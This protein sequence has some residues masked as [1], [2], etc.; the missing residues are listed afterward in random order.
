M[1]SGDHR[2]G[3]GMIGICHHGGAGNG[4][5]AVIS[6][7]GGHRNRM[8]R[9][10]HN[11]STSNGMVAVVPGGCGHRHRVIGVSHNRCSGDGMISKGR[12]SHRRDSQSQN[13]FF[14]SITFIS[15][16]DNNPVRRCSEQTSL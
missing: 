16:P 3:D 6:G 7:G 12:E 9:I 8:V 10:C 15:L 2:R 11:G 14:Q 4:M 13:N 5:V 1:I